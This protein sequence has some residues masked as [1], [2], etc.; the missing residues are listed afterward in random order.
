MLLQGACGSEIA[1]IAIPV[2][3]REIVGTDD[4]VVRNGDFIADC[5]V[6]GYNAV[7]PHSGNKIG[8]VGTGLSIGLTGGIPCV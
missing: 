2:V 6:Q 3:E 8:G 7:A 4:S 5:E 1:P